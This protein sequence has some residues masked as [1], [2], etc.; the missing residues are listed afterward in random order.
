MAAVCS[1]SALSAN[2]QELQ[3]TRTIPGIQIVPDASG[4]ITT[5]SVNGP[6]DS[7]G[8]FFQSLGTNGRSCATCH[9][10]SQAM[11]I[12]ASGI[13]QRFRRPAV[14]DPLFAAV[15]GANCPHARQD[16]AGG[17]QPAAAARTHSHIL[18]PLP[19]DAQFSISVVHDPYGCAITTDPADGQPI[20]SVYRRPL[21]TTNLGFLSTIMFDGRETKQP[22]N[23]RASF[24]ANLAADLTQQAIDAIAIHAQATQAPTRGAARRHHRLRARLIY[25][26]GV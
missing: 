17:P 19:A 16:S 11:S 25:R 10:A 1:M 3:P 6:I 22:L 13:Q 7:H 8:A 18:E 5:L 9:V 23:V 24:P 15:D 4:V 26:A 20:V 12:S 2:A 14:R 21:P